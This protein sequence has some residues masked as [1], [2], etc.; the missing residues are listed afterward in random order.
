MKIY[1]KIVYDINDNIIAEDSYISLAA[2]SV[3]AIYT[4]RCYW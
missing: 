3:Y 1:N 4:A 2:S